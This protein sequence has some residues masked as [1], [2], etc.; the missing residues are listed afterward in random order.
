VPGRMR[1]RR[2]AKRSKP[3][4]IYTELY[5]SLGYVVRL[6]MKSISKITRK[7]NLKKE[8]CD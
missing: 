5:E 4:Y 6:L 8:S 1:Q 2:I 7:I 3:I